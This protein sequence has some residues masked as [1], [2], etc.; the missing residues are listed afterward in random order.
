[1]KTDKQKE[2]HN[3]ASRKYYANNKEKHRLLV[4][5]RKQ[6]LY[7]DRVRK[8]G[9]D[10]IK[11]KL[12]KERYYE[13]HREEIKIKDRLKY[14][15]RKSIIQSQNK[16]NKEIINKKYREHISER[17]KIDPLFKLS[18]DI[19]KLI[20]ISIKR[21]GYS[22]KSKTYS[23]LGCTW[24]ELKQHLENKFEPWMNWQNRGKYNGELN[25][26]WDVD[27]I[28]PVST[29]K[30]EEEMMNLNHYTNLQPLDSFINRYVK[31]NKIAS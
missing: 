19:P 13:K 8:L 27:H 18:R 22:K 24:E 26:G 10:P 25:Y 5:N 30:S 11:V 16:A 21:Y 12:Q 4:K 1:M 20:R 29:A 28:I 9:I 15:R 23:I 31:S 2:I 14:L 6:L 7:P 3:K 17:M